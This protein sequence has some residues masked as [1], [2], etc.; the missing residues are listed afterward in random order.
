MVS[1]LLGKSARA[2]HRAEH[3]LLLNSQDHRISSTL[4]FL[5][6]SDDFTYVC[7][8]FPRECSSLRKEAI[9]QCSHK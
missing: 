4:P 2:S 1:L 3:G 6:I 9:V 5:V 7:V 8:S